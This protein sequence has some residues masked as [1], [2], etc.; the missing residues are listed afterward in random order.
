MKRM[1]LHIKYSAK[2][3]PA[4]FIAFLLL[5]ASA[6]AQTF[7]ATVSST[8][9]AVGQT[10]E[11]RF[12]LSGQDLSSAS[13]FRAPDFRNFL[14]LSGPNQSTNMQIYNGQMSSSRTFSYYLQGQSEGQFTI[15]SASLNVNGKSLATDPII[16]DVL[17][18]NKNTNQN[19]NRSQNNR[20]GGT[21]ENQEA[22]L[23]DEVK[24]NL[25]IRAF[26]D[27]NNT[28][29][30]EQVTVTYKLYTRYDLRQTQ[31]SKLPSYTGFWTEELESP[32]KLLF[33]REEYDGKI[34]NSC[35]LKKVALFPTQSGKL[36]VTPLELKV[37]LQV[38]RRSN[39]NA[40][41]DFFNDPFFDRFP[42]FG[43]TVEFDI[44]SN[45][46]TLNVN[47]IPETNDKAFTGAVGSYSM[48]IAFDKENVKRNEPVTLTLTLRGTGNIRLLEA[49]E[50]K[51]PNSFDTYDPEIEDNI[52]KGARISGSKTYE[53]LIVPRKS[54]N[55][56]IPEIRFVYYN[57][58][59]DEFVEIKKG[60]FRINVEGGSANISGIDGKGYKEEVEQL[61]DDIRFIKTTANLTQKGVYLY[62]KAIFYIM[63]FLPLIG[64]I[65]LFVWQKRKER[66]SEDPEMRK[67]L[68]AR[69]MAKVRLKKAAEL[70]RKNYVQE[71][72][73]EIAAATTGYLEDKLNLPKAD[74][75]VDSAI[76]TLTAR[77]F[78]ESLIKSVKFS[79]ERCDFIRYAPGDHGGNEMNQMYESTANLIVDLE[80]EFS[81]NKK[82]K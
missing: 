74:F 30:G 79:I 78:S 57:A 12:T 58:D 11:V 54:G 40:F 9:V 10:F 20:G 47:P 1:N 4:L 52:N 75:S 65:L 35:L 82:K 25:F 72:Y 62:D 60:P 17:A 6:E 59:K 18:G 3:F 2:L 27:R 76:S 7:K 8:S 66:L 5:T 36:T 63:V 70:M 21:E 23:E 50:I 19:Q 22:S 39:R 44:V 24:E 77:G 34:F 37:P 53:Y 13:N 32:T 61:D 41:D 29:K 28:I 68:R 81:A 64:F 46:V 48:D 45:S 69:K 15:G 14:I 80:K 55:Y 71:F 33:E 73:D 31:I 26:V 56:T 51:F 49:P 43:E 16:I 67:L 42:G 38:Q